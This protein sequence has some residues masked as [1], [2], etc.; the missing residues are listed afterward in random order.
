MNSDSVDFEAQLKDLAKKEEATIA[1]DT[2]HGDFTDKLVSLL[3]ANSTVHVYGSLGGVVK[4]R[5]ID[6][7]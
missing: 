2:I 3:P 1:F 5:L 6:E 7:I 4:Y